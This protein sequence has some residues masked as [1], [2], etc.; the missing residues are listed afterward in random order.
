MDLIGSQARFPT[1]MHTQTFSESLSVCSID[2][3]W[4]V[5]T[6][7]NRSQQ[8]GGIS[9]LAAILMETG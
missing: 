9:P 8:T 6:G 4:D 7:N 5:E 1:R 2:L 3:V